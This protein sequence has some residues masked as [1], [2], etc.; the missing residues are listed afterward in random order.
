MCGIAGFLR[1]D[2]AAADPALLR[3]M[4]ARLAHRGPD[5]AGILAEGPLGLAHRRL[6]IIDLETGAQPMERADLGRAIVFNGEIYN[7]VELR[8][9]LVRLGHS[10]QTTSDTEVLLVG[11]AVWGDSLFEKLR[12]MFAFAIWER[13]ARRLTVVRDPLGK[14]P[15]QM[16]ILPGRLFAF[17]SEAKA[18]FAL[19]EISRAIEPE[20]IAAYLDW[21]YVPE[22]LRLFRDIERLQAGEFIVVE[23][24]RTR[25]SL[26]APDCAPRVPA[27]LSFDE[28]CAR[29][30]AAV[31][32][33]TRIRLRADVPLGVFL[34]GGIDSTLVALSAASQVPGK[35]RTFTV[36]FRGE[37]D[38]RPFAAQVARAI[39]S[40]HTELEITLDAPGVAQEILA[41]FDEPFGDSSAV[42][43]LAMSRETAKSVKVVLAGDGGDEIFGGYGT[44]LR[45][46]QA[47]DAASAGGRAGLLRSTF[48]RAVGFARESAKRLPAPLSARI[49]QLIKP[50]RKGLDAAADAPDAL[51]DPAL[52]QLLMMRITRADRSRD[53]LAPLF[54]HATSAPR[55]LAQEMLARVPRDGAALRAAMLCDRRVYLPGDIL[56]KVDICAMRAALE[57]RAPL[58][59]DDVIALA[60]ALPLD[61]LVSRITGAAE[62]TFGKRPL[63]AL[64]AQ[65]MGAQFAYRP[66]QGFGAPLQSWLHDPRF[67]SIVH[68][69][70]ASPTSPLAD[71]FAPRARER[72]WSDFRAGK[73]WLAQEV[74]N[75]IAL[76]A[77]ARQ[78]RPT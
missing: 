49:A 41:H 45:H 3:E 9:E 67:V 15:V 47:S 39:G 13:A 65:R 61:F 4:E 37:S 28:A 8:E 44:Y 52:R 60:D 24:G 69:G 55:D 11:H 20:A 48:G 26:Y 22:Q 7:Y 73:Q 33:A 78:T 76:D 75:L 21:M 19:P 40:E 10:F 54:G 77:W 53:Q 31:H 29:V 1:L 30:D 23:D 17:A 51:A 71:W 59:D 56:K 6:S 66:K 5:G 32:E 18:L 43:V 70:F 57:V 63:K 2:G 62:E 42:P 27:N 34:S 16:A 68:E 50:L 46:L 38:E 64:V 74:W 35:L 36:G 72:I 12:G 25:R 14:K 58:L